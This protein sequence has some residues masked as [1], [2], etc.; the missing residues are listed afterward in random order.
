VVTASFEHEG[1]VGTL[2]VLTHF[3][4]THVISCTKHDGEFFRLGGTAVNEV[5][6]YE[7][8]ILNLPLSTFRAFVSKDHIVEGRGVLSPE[9]WS[10]ADL[11]CYVH[12]HYPLDMEGKTPEWLIASR[13][14]QN[15]HHIFVNLDVLDGGGNLIKRYRVSP[16]TG[17][18]VVHGQLSQ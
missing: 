6:I 8:V 15:A 18:Y 5:A 17:E 1:N 2:T 12:E 16:F 13:P 11:H 7:G 14:L 10:D 3:D 9:N 4:T